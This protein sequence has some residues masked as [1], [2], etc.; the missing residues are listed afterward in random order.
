[1]LY[2]KKQNSQY[3]HYT[4]SA[5]R[6]KTGITQI[7]GR[8]TTPFG[9]HKYVNQETHYSIKNLLNYFSLISI[10]THQRKNNER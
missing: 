4:L 2:W 5:N 1:M 6:I 3:T 10:D 9:K 7:D 8:S